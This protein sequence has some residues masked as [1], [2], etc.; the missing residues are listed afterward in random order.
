MNRVQL[1]P[2]KGKNIVLVDLSNADEVEIAK[3]LGEA[4][5]L[6]ARQGPKNARVLTDVTNATYNPQVSQLIKQFTA[7]NTPYVRASA[8]VGIEGVRYVLLQ[9][10]IMLTRR[11]IKVFPDREKAK[12]FLSSN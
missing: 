9:T 5:G 1:F 11:E 2:H 3:T 7:N 4:S 10:V 8:V 12:D 6:V